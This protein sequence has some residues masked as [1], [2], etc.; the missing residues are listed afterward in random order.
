MRT[1]TADLYRVV[2]EQ[3]LEKQVLKDIAEGNFHAL[4]IVAVRCSMRARSMN[5]PSDMPA[6]W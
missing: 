4:N 1:P 6:N 2:A 5:F 3:S